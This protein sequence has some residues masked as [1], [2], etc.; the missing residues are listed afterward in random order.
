MPHC[1]HLIRAAYAEGARVALATSHESV[2]SPNFA[3]FIKPLAGMYELI[4][5]GALAELQ[6]EAARRRRLEAIASQR[7]GARLFVLE[8]DKFLPQTVHL[9]RPTARR[10]TVLLIRTP[11]HLG[12][13]ARTAM[14]AC[15]KLVWSLFAHLRGVDT[16]VIGPAR[17]IEDHL[18]RGFL[19]EC[20]DPVEFSTTPSS[21]SK[22]RQTAD[23]T[24]TR[25]WFGI[26]GNVV[27]RKNPL[28]ALESLQDVDPSSTGLLLAGTVDAE[29]LSQLEGPIARFRTSGGEVRIIDRLLPDEDLDAA[30]AS[31]DV[32]LFL[33]SGDGPS[34]ILGKA[35]AAGVST[36]AA[37]SKAL[38]KMQKRLGGG[39]WSPLRKS[40]IVA[41]LRE[42]KSLPRPNPKTLA[43]GPEFAK[44]LLNRSAAR[45]EGQ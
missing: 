6:S 15:V 34:Q 27:A 3:M 28:L 22:M 21:I 43:G 40:T 18:R 8:G 16:A 2:D 17:G 19:R 39:R 35:V 14:N 33:H 25:T 36:L 13:S 41:Q 11:L 1:A 12:N 45:Q 4:D 20:P 31:V 23:L 30:I 38:R 42:A 7:H 26:F 5:L 24:G 44:T 29:L 9:S 10:T 32:A 37:G